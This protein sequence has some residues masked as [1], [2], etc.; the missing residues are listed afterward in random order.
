MCEVYK[1]GTEKEAHLGV[2][3]DSPFA[4]F[5][6]LEEYEATTTR[7]AKVEDGCPGPIGIV[8]CP[9]TSDG[10]GRHSR[11]VLYSA[12]GLLLF[13]PS[14]TDVM[15]TKGCTNDVEDTS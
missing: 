10:T 2:T 12:T 13:R 5:G 3:R 9:H 4:I 7:L 11:L 6:S 1:W 8:N 15:N 14:A